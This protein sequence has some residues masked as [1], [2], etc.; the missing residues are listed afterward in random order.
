[1]KE[2]ETT[3]L[4]LT[5]HGLVGLNYRSI[6]IS[7]KT[8]H[9]LTMAAYTNEVALWAPQPYIVPFSKIPHSVIG[10][11]SLCFSINFQTQDQGST[12]YIVTFPGSS[13]KLD[14][15]GAFFS[16][17]AKVC[18]LML[19]NYQIIVICSLSSDIVHVRHSVLIYAGTCSSK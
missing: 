19:K 18:M 2:D 6:Q 8:S 10:A 16:H 3:N 12:I 14:N 13:S 1:V 4:S 7:S 9:R 5:T 17:H 15:G 11:K